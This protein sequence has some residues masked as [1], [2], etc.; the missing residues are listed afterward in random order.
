MVQDNRQLS[1]FDFE[2]QPIFVLQNQV[3]YAF[4]GVITK[5][6]FVA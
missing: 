5:N 2:N 3:F 1:L 6:Q 4:F